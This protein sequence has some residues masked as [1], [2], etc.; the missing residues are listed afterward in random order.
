VGTALVGPSIGVGCD[1]PDFFSDPGLGRV[2]FRRTIGILPIVAR[3]NRRIAEELTFST[4]T[5]DRHVSHILSKIGA[6]N[7]AEAAAYA[8]KQRLLS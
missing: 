1:I 3:S 4:N 8:A 5:V 2:V 6:A 7:R